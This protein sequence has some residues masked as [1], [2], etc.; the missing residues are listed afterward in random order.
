MQHAISVALRR[1]QTASKSGTDLVLF[2]RAEAVA[3]NKHMR[4]FGASG[5]TRGLGERIMKGVRKYLVAA[6]VAMLGACAPAAE[7]AELGSPERETTLIV[8][9]NN[10]H[11]MVIY[12]VTGSQRARI[13]SVNSMSTTR[14]RITDSLAGGFGQ[15][16]LVADPIGSNRAYALPII[17][18]VPGSEV[19]V[20]IENNIAA[21]SYSVF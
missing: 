21:S 9:N 19:Q 7:Q 5:L 1:I 13:G 16:R 17:N 18:V 8:Q 3:A 10:W 20:R 11:D 6:T 15:L 12:V 4:S 2:G 14:F